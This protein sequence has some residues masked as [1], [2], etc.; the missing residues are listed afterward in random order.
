MKQILILTVIL[1][2]SVLNAY[3]IVYDL[4][5]DQPDL[6][7]TGNWTL[8]RIKG[9]QEYGTPGS[10]S[11]P[12]FGVRLLLPVGYEA[13]AIEV[14]KSEPSYYKLSD[15]VRPIQQQYPFSL[16]P[17]ATFTEPDPQIY[18]RDSVYPFTAHNGANTEFLSGH[19]IAMTAVTPV[20]YN[21]VTNE[22]T[23]YA[24]VRVKVTAIPSQRA[25]AARQ[26]L[27]QDAYTGQRLRQSIDNPDATPRYETRTVGYE[28]IYIIDAAMPDAWLP[29]KSIHEQRGM[30]VL[31]KPVQEIATEQTGVDLQQKIRN[32]L[33]SMFASN[34]VRYVLLCGDTDVIPHRG[35][36]VNMGNGSEV[37]ADIP[38]D[39][40]YSCLDGS[41]NN[42]G[43]SY[44]G[45]YNE[46]DL[47]PELSIGRFCYNN[48][49]EINHFINKVMSYMI[50]PVESEVKTANFIGEWLWEGP[51]WGG[52]YLDEMIGGSS[53]NGHTTVGVP[54]TW[55]ITTLYDRTYGA[56]NSWGAAQ[57]RP[58]L[59]QGANLVNHLGHS[60]TTYAFRLNNNQVSATTITNNGSNHNFSIYFTQGCY[61]GAFDNRT[62]TV[63][64]YTQD[65]ITE[66]FNG[67]ATSAAAMISHSRYGWG[68][69]GSTNGASQRLHR[70][71]IDALFGESI[72]PAGEMLTD[73]KIDIIPFIYGAPVMYWITYETNLF[74]D[75]SM[76]VWTNTPQFIT[77]QL[78]DTWIM[79]VNQYQIQTNA[80]NATVRIKQN[81]SLIYE[82]TADNTGLATI[83]MIQTLTPGDYNLHITAPNFY[84]YDTVFNVSASQSAYIVC[85]D[86]T[87]NDDDGLL[88]AGEIVDLSMVIENIGLYDLLES[89]TLTLTAGSAVVTVLSP[90]ITFAPIEAGN[91]QAV[92]NVFSIRINSGFVDNTSVPMIL[93]ASYGEVVSSTH[94][95][96]I[97]NAPSLI[98]SSYQMNTTDE[99]ILPGHTAQ[100]NISISNQGSGHSY[101]AV[102]LVLSDDPMLS[103]SATE[104]S[105]PFSPAGSNDLYTN[106]FSITVSP[107]APIGSI[108][109][110]HY[111]LIPTNG[112]GGE[113]SIS[114]YVG[115][116]NYT[117]EMGWQNWIT[118]S[119]SASFVN[120]W[121]RSNQRNY[122]TGGTYS[123]KFGAEGTGSY[124]G[125]AYGA[126]ISPQFTLGLNSE[127]KFYHWMDA[128]NHST[129]TTSAWDGGLVQMSLNNSA[130]FQITP[131]GGYPYGI[132]NNPA[133]PFPSGTPVFSG[134]FGWQECVFNLSNYTGEARFRFLFGSDGYVSG[135]GWYIDD[136][137]LITEIVSNDDNTVIPANYRLFD[138]Y[139]NPFNPTTT[140]AFS[141]PVGTEVSLEIYNVKGQRVRSLIHSSELDRG[142]HRIVWNGMDDHNRS[143]GSGVYFY[144][145]STPTWTQTKK[146]LM[147]K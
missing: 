111:Y 133:S 11:L 66:K 107:D 85:T 147:M 118:Q 120:Q 82:G 34:S 91:T 42:N 130:W 14:E 143:V 25:E 102:L 121:H 4:N 138:N 131:V 13:K 16:M 105:I 6:R 10:P 135:E 144:R 1:V 58:L 104:I 71:F 86:I 127:L 56:N 5:L 32:Y 112:E 54:T 141:L 113:G 12:W 139:P 122:S 136:V 146:M 77:A 59:S 73:G 40:Y 80:P 24:H 116:V 65:S 78:P 37:D 47:I 124:A 46:C 126:L 67:I 93:T 60:N 62:T 48:V 61:A 81:G 109:T 33:I 55:N 108:V 31:F 17:T 140:I 99:F 3:E 69:P 76:M 19:P 142:S 20:E 50:I 74:G 18:Q 2:A 87:V 75:P 9:G 83:T 21:P 137:R 100:M 88:H 53:T 68:M 98:I 97:L 43:N 44:W 27:Q 117:F 22:L 52:D 110:L 15:P 26:L 125:S 63:G 114:F 41:W 64:N 92:E 29:L 45:E 119:L 106:L 51:T 115:L 36:F 96:L 38:A 30:S 89:G 103:V 23:S 134:S 70:Q 39:M 128:E 145:I 49:T 79:G 57:V 7:V 28:Y 90:T 35:F 123:M 72:Y 8:V 94:Y 101:D 129:I 84:S 132:Q 95:N